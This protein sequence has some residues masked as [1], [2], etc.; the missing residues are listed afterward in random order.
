MQRSTV[1]SSWWSRFLLVPFFLG[2]GACPAV[3]ER[4]GLK[5]KNE[6]LLMC[7]WVGKEGGGEEEGICEFVY[8]VRVGMI[9]WL[10][11][12]GRKCAACFWWW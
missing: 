2:R 11:G 8:S 12:L 7:G 5:N 3:M 10:V 1:W 6:L 9:D 4:W